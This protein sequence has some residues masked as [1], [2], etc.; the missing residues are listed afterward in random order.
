MED[1]KKDTT[2]LAKWT[3]VKET[4]LK[5]EVDVVKNCRG[6]A[7]SGK[8]ARKA[9]RE[10]RKGLVELGKLTF[11]VDLANKAARNAKADAEDAT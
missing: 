10:V 8:R 5:C 9:F 3:V 2:L 6:N 1:D 7:S 11:E 4:L